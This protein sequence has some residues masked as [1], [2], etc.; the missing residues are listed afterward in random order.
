[1]N[2][3]EKEKKKIRAAGGALQRDVVQLLA[4]RGFVG[5]LIQAL[6]FVN[7]FMFL[8]HGITSSLND[9][10]A[11]IDARG[12]Y[13]ITRIVRAECYAALLA[14]HRSERRLGGIFAA[15]GLRQLLVGH[16]RAVLHILL[17]HGIS[18]FSARRLAPPR[19]GFS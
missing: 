10:Q 4:V 1:M 15:G 16:F 19:A 9:S 12:A 17:F 18:S 11:P 6:F 14:D 2:K 7:R 5:Q 3:F 13:E 8:V